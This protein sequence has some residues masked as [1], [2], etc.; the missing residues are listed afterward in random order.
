MHDR[1]SLRLV[2]AAF[3]QPSRKPTR[4]L[5]H[6]SPPCPCCHCT[7]LNTQLVTQKPRRNFKDELED[8]TSP[9][10]EAEGIKCTIKSGNP[11]AA[12]AKPTG[13]KMM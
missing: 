2:Q 6:R 5:V 9:D 1:T 13:R 10:Q 12:A 7:R 8:R 11:T 4:A 3:L